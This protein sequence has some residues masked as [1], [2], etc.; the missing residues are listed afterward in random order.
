MCQAA[1]EKTL[2]KLVTDEAFRDRFFTDP[3]TASFQAGLDLSAAELEA[4]GRVPVAALVRLSWVLDGRIC[5][6]LVAGDSETRPP[7]GAE[8]EGGE[9]HGSPRRARAGGEEDGFP[10]ESAVS[11][12][13]S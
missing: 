2:G 11:R 4:L 7:S 9:R 13:H 1:V 3:A 12:T 10:G 8:N 5:R 6:L